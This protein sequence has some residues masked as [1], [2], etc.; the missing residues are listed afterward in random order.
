MRQLR[1]SKRLRMRL[2]L[3]ERSKPKLRP[4]PRP[5][6]N[7]SLNPSVN[8]ILP[9]PLPRPSLGFSFK[10]F[11]LFASTLAFALK[12]CTISG[13]LRIAGNQK[14]SDLEF[15]EILRSMRNNRKTICNC[16]IICTS[17]KSNYASV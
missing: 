9:L 10:L 12:I 14:I 8:L 3:R 2:M 6:S 15:L 17:S 11:L 4:R 5:L 13:G 7:P 1:L 16:V